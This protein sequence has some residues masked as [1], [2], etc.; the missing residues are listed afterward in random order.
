ML[1]KLPQ[2]LPAVSANYSLCCPAQRI[3]SSDVY[4]SPARREV[5]CPLSSLCVLPP[6]LL[7][8]PRGGCSAVPLG[9]GAGGQQ[10]LGSRAPS[11]ARPVR[12]G[13]H[14]SPH[15]SA[16]ACGAL[17]PPAPGRFWNP[18]RLLQAFSHL[19]LSPSSESCVPGAPSLKRLRLCPAGWDTPAPGQPS[20]S[21]HH[22]GPGHRPQLVSA[23]AVWWA[24]EQAGRGRHVMPFPRSR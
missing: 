2:R 1:P 18:G 16:S 15:T 11:P 14:V 20:Q 6:P 13:R 21:R 5:L 3:R 24:G 17:L 19:L 7:W 9:G 4:F 8:G 23:G 10:V 22:P 12:S